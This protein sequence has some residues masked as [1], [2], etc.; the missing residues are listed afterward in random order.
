MEI[1]GQ[2]SAEIDNQALVSFEMARICTR[3]GTLTRYRATSRWHSRYEDR[4]IR[5]YSFRRMGRL[6]Q[7]APTS[8]MLANLAMR[9]LDGVIAGLANKND[10][11]YTRYADDM[12]LSTKNKEFDRDKCR[13][14]INSIYETMGQFGLSPN[15]AKTNILSP[16]SRKIVLG[17]LVDATEPRLPRDFRN[18]MR[19]HIYYLQDPEVGPA[20]HAAER[21]FASIL[22]CRNHI[23]GLAMFARQIEPLYG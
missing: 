9:A 13:A 15:I 20:K 19:Q 6:P 18:L 23:Y 21:G 17:L 10:M 4:T 5:Q 14:V 11:I 22:G 8:P 12:T 7:G 16:G 2:I 1:P 3:V